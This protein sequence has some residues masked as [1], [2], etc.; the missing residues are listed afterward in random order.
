[1]GVYCVYG[2][3]CGLYVCESQEVG[4]TLIGEDGLCMYTCKCL[5]VNTTGSVRN[6]LLDSLLMEA[7]MT[8]E[9]TAKPRS[10]GAASS[11]IF[12]VAFS[13]DRKEPKFL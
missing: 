13:V 7:A 10:P 12:T 3:V 6:T 2:R 9:L 8:W 1:M 4:G 5:S 11:S